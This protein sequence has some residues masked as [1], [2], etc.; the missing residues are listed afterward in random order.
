MMTMRQYLDAAMEMAKGAGEIQMR[1][2]RMPALESETKQN[3]FDVVT[4][5]DKESERYIKSYG[6]M[7]V[8][9]RGRIA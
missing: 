2:F 1:Y 6:A 9:Y 5:A 7:H 3:A 4:V 8:P